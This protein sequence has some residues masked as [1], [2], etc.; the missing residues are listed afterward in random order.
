MSLRDSYHIPHRI[1]GILKG[2]K[3]MEIN[4]NLENTPYVRWLD[5][6]YVRNHLSETLCE[7]LDNT[8]GVYTDEMRKIER[9]VQRL[10]RKCI[11]LEGQ[12]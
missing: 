10:D 2:T 4:K 9:E 11:A 6:T 7:M 8:N 1:A 12:I 3:K 5:I